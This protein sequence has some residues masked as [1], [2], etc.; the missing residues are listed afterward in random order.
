MLL[1]PEPMSNGSSTP[2]RRARPVRTLRGAG[3]ISAARRYGVD[4]GLLQAALARTPAERLAMLEA[5]AGFIRGMRKG[6]P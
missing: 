1:P 4:L 6:E 3:P 5:N 2:R